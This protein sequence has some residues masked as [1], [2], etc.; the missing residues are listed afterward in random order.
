MP[1]SLTPESS[2][3]DDEFSDTMSQADD[4]KPEPDTQDI[5][6]E[7]VPN[8][9]EDDKAKVNLEELFEDSDSDI[10]FPSSAPQF[11]SEDEPSQPV[12]ALYALRLYYPIQC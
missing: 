11:K 4:I 7:D 2:P 6:M 10:E 1:H 8:P 5:A 9:S 12:A 3:E